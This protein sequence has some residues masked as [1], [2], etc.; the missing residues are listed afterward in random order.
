MMMHSP[1]TRV[2]LLRVALLV[3][4]CTLGFAR[5][6]QASQSYPPYLKAALDKEFPSVNHCVPLCTACHKT[7]AGGPGNINLFGATLESSKIGLLPGGSEQDV[8]NAIH[9][10]AITMP[11]IDSDGDGVSDVD[12]LNAGDSPSIAGPAGQ[13]QFCSD[14]QYGCGARIAAA[15]PVD[16]LSLLSAGLVTL[17]LVLSRRR[18]SKLRA[19][20]AR[21]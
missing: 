13:G 21:G 14:L 8:E 11:P 10:L 19:R 15:P 9:A 5:S 12:E 16:R 7:T 6:A 1:K 2:S 20:R 18:R 3:G 17:G 4:L